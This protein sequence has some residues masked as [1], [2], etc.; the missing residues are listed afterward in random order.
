[1]SIVAVERIN[2]YIDN[3][4]EVKHVNFSMEYTGSEYAFERRVKRPD[5]KNLKD[6]YE[7]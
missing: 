2:E 1:M 7:S 3:K 4:H 6:S 5:D